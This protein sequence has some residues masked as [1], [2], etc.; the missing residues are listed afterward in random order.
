MKSRRSGFTLLELIIVVI[1]IGIL[2]SIALPRYIRIAEKG[3]C[4]EAKSVLGALRSSQMRYSAEHGI[5]TGNVA[6]LD[7]NFQTPKFF[8][9][10]PIGGNSVSLETSI[11]GGVTRNAVDLAAGTTNYVINISQSGNM[12]GDAA[13]VNYM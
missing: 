3:R 13:A 10:A 8:T 12:S 9:Y 2:A 11:V 7:L 4:A 1:V 5:F 6:D